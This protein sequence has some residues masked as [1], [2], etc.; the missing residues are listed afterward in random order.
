M[1]LSAAQVRLPVQ[2][3]RRAAKRFGGRQK[4]AADWRRLP[5]HRPAAGG[6]GVDACSGACDRPPGPPV[7]RR[8]VR[9][10]GGLPQGLVSPPVCAGVT[11]NVCCWGLMKQHS[12]RSWP[13]LCCQHHST[14]SHAGPGTST[15]LTME[16]ISSC[17]ISLLCCLFRMLN[18]L[19]QFMLHECAQGFVL[20][21]VR[22]E[23]WHNSAYSQGI[24]RSARTSVMTPTC[25][26]HARG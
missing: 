7:L 24:E 26:F 18:S 2:Q 25:Y 12:S 21:Q 4:S 14:R 10:L 23:S 1:A 22:H 11:A 3:L 6:A 8:P 15:A 13:G 19:Q 5:R 16:E 20:K 9:H 17:R